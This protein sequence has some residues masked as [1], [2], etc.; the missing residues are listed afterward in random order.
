MIFIEKSVFLAVN[1]SLRWLSN[2]S[3]V[4]LVQ[5]FFASDWSAGF[6]TFLLASQW[7]ED[8]ANLT[9]TPAENDQN[10]SNHS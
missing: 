10:S 7:L 4:H 3:S 5:V 8:C 1:A 6:G 2:V 9:P